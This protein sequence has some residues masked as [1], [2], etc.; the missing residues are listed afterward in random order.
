MS[1]GRR[2]KKDVGKILVGYYFVSFDEVE[3]KFQLFLIFI[4]RLYVE[5]TNLRIWLVPSHGNT[6]GLGNFW[7]HIAWPVVC[8]WSWRSRPQNGPCRRRSSPVRPALCRMSCNFS[9]LYKRIQ[10][11]QFPLSR[12]EFSWFSIQ[13]FSIIF[14]KSRHLNIPLKTL[15][16]TR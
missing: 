6:W 3:I 10:I 2:V 4:Y 15:I 7:Y 5:R 16:I 1:R 8:R 14:Q 13:L 11:N 9:H 12:W